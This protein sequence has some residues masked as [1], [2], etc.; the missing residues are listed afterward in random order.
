MNNNYFKFEYELDNFQKESCEIINNN[1][2][3]LVSAHTGSGKTNIALYAIGKTLYEKGKAVYVSPIKSLSNQKFNEFSKH[4]NSLG[5]LTGDIKINPTADVLIIT[6]EILRNSLLKENS[7]H[8][9]NFD[10]NQIKC[11][12]LDEIHYINNLQRGK[13]WEEILINLN[14]NI[15]IIMLSGTIEGVDIF[16]KWMY[17]IKDIE[18]KSVKTIKRPVPLNHGIWVDNNIDYFLLNDK[19][20]EKVWTNSLH[21]IKK[22]YNTVN[23]SDFGI[24]FNCIKYLH[25]KELTPVNV[26]I[27][28]KQLIENLSSKIPYTF[29]SIDEINKVNDLW[30][31]YLNKYKKIY[32][33]TSEWNNIYKL[34][35]KGIGIHHSG[36][37]PILKEFIEI[38]YSQKL[39]KVLLTTETFAMGVNMPT[40]TVLFYS[41]Y[42]FDSS[43]R[44]L[45]SEEYNQMAG[46][47]GR[48]GIDEIGNVI[49]YP[50]H[51]LITETNAKKIILSNPQKIN[52]KFII[53]YEF[54][55]KEYSKQCLKSTDINIIVNNIIEIYKCSL[56]N[57]QESCGVNIIIP[58]NIIIA[59]HR[60]NKINSILELDISVKINPKNKKQL[61]YEKIL[62]LDVIKSNNFDMIQIEKYINTND[63][64]IYKNQINILINYFKELNFI[65]TNNL[66]TKQ[67]KLLSEINECNPFILM[68]ILSDIELNKLDLFEFISLISICINETKSKD[69]V[70]FDELD[71]SQTFKDILQR[72]NHKIN[73]YTNKECKVNN[74]LPFPVW[75]NW[76]VNYHN[77]NIVKK[78]VLNTD[79]I[80]LTDVSI[81]Q[82]DFIKTILRVNNILLNI[83]NIFKSLNEIHFINLL[84][85]F[86]EKLIKGIVINDSLY[87]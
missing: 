21:K 5:I 31:K 87:I 82:G 83:S 75:S 49:I 12:I 25:D 69:D 40:K 7:E 45:L 73:N 86:E 78:W 17:K 37:T 80:Q 4:F 8:N 67:G 57:Y 52:S 58:D 23:K 60:V 72:L 81:S 63:F 85:G 51:D 32:E 33:K 65:D 70:Y 77:I 18:C 29:L 41:L 11:V 61:S 44:V 9:N 16:T 39:L 22:C 54:V 74:K 2:N 55:L 15:Q 38:L 53:D 76:I 20:I 10:I 30:N 79:E 59:F 1:E 56:F 46:R 14:K 68:E 66:I 27:L 43:N 19:W 36:I 13:V 62:L 24:F 28:S 50:G 71:I 35:M 42:K 6:A 47:A 3:L 34:I 84:Y 48:R 64:N 26:F